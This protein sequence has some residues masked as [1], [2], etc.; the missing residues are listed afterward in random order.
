MLPH[1]RVY[2]WGVP[3]GHANHWPSATPTP[4]ILHFAESYDIADTTPPPFPPVRS[5]P[6]RYY[7]THSKCC[8]GHA[9]C[10]YCGTKPGSNWSTDPAGLTLPLD[11]LL[12][13]YYHLE[14]WACCDCVKLL[15]TNTHPL[16]LIE[17]EQARKLYTAANLV[18]RVRHP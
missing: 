16:S 15:T 12:R 14:L 2:A 9:L 6:C 4:G 7:C 3:D 8:S 18:L 13:L 5:E 10:H 17:S 1:N 11:S